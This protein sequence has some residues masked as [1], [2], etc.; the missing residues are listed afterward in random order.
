MTRVHSPW[1]HQL[2]RTRL[3]AK[4][5][6]N[7]DTDVAIVGGGI[8]GIAT[9]YFVLR[10]TR[11]HVLLLEANKVAHGATGHNAGQIT[12]YFERPF[13]DMVNEFGLEQAAEGQ[14]L[15]E[16]AWLLLEQIK[17]EAHLKV[18]LQRFTGFAGC[19]T[20]PQVMIHLQNNWLRLEG[21]L[22]QETILIAEDASFVSHIPKRF[23]FLYK[24]VPRKD[25]ISLLE[26]KDT[27]Y[28]ALL[29][30]QKGCM[31]SALFCEE[32]VG[33]LLAQFPKRFTIVEHTWIESVTLF[34]RKAVLQ[35][36]IYSVNC[37]R[38]V[39][40]TN[41]FENFTI[42]NQ[43]GL[44]IDPKFHHLVSGWVG[45]MAGFL[46]ELDKP[47][48]AISYFDSDS[49]DV[50]DTY[51]YLTRRPFDLEQNTPANLVCIGGP[52]TPLEG[53][54]IYSA[55]NPYPESVTKA[56]SGFIKRSYSNSPE[57]Y[58]FLWHGLMGYTPNRIRVIGPEPRNPVLLYNLGCNGV[59]ILPSLY[60]GK[61]ISEVFANTRMPKSIFDPK[62]IPNT[63][64]V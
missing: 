19:R 47:P 61:R 33:Y 25:I 28:T 24:L 10:D 41:G 48:T 15:V 56:I 57:E 16:S 45:Y 62:D 13:F 52:E 55:T 39:L 21:G 37:E 5:T 11:K 3:A 35:A 38:V 34:A 54:E 17:T 32:L 20:L 63:A 29:A 9:A 40:C 58:S 23:R 1:L 7:A 30:Y 59:G 14:R 31:N 46:E 43:D 4:L 26:T 6:T 27:Q 49:A 22:T 18:P 64:K 60:G 36:G 12:S 51:F 42:D 50:D 44:P 53:E 2:N 8:A